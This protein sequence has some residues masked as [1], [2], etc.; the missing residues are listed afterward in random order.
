MNAQKS[1]THTHG[2]DLTQ[3]AINSIRLIRPSI[4][5]KGPDYKNHNNDITG[6]INEEVSV[7]KKVRSKVYYTSGIIMSSSKI[8]N[9]YFNNLND[10]QSKFI[11]K[12]KKVS[13]F[14]KILKHI[15]DMKKS[16]ILVIG[17]IIIDEYWDE[18]GPYG[19]LRAH[20]WSR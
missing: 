8:I 4:F 3:T 20:I 5:C 10:S 19:S 12:I 11:N 13:N 1:R 18:L 9:K 16:K 6:K 17:E 15:N 7:A 2:L 14:N